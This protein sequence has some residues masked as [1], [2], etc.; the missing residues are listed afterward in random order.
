M[1][2]LPYYQVKRLKTKAE[3]IHENILYQSFGTAW[4]YVEYT[5]VKLF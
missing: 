3:I 1:L 5:F 4:L 2:L